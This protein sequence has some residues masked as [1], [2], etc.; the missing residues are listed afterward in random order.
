MTRAQMLRAADRCADVV[1]AGD[2]VIG[3]DPANG[4]DLGA[5]VTFRC[6]S[7]GSL[8]L[9]K[10][11]VGDPLRSHPLWRRYVASLLALRRAQ[12]RWA[13]L[14]ARIRAALAE[15]ERVA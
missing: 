14:P 7:D 9:V 13:A 1:A 12:P 11:E 10:M 8:T 2:Y 6:E 15:L 4:R 5:K 3:I